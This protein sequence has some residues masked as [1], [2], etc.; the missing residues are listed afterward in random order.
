MTHYHIFSKKK[1]IGFSGRGN[2]RLI[3]LQRDKLNLHKKCES[4]GN[5]PTQLLK[6]RK[7]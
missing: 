1:K 5:Q 6:F 3:G 4:S 2:G 7:S